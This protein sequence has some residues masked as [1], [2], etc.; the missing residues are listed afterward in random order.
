[1]KKQPSFWTSNNDHKIAFNNWVRRRGYS[2]DVF[3]AVEKRLKKSQNVQSPKRKTSKISVDHCFSIIFDKRIRSKPLDLVTDDI[4]TCDI[5][6]KTIRSLVSATKNVEAQK[7][8]ENFLR[9]Q[10]Q[11]ADSRG[12][13]FTYK[14]LFQ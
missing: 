7:E 14:I 9:K 1:M 13:N 5:W 3:N 11:A 12:V 8:H 6:V 2:T 4:R 10:F